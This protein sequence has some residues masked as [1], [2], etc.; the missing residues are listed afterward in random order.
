VRVC[1]NE[2]RED[3]PPSTVNDIL[4]VAREVRPNLVNDSIDNSDI[5]RTAVQWAHVANDSYLRHG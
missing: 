1:V 3:K 5:D 4:T 2:S